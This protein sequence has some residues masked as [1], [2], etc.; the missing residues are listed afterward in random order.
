MNALSK[1]PRESALFRS[2]R[3]QAVRIPKGMEF[4]DGLKK[5]VIRKV[6]KS[7]ILTPIDALAPVISQCRRSVTGRYDPLHAR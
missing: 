4:P 6:G 5:V 3:S 7:I 1:S 2:N